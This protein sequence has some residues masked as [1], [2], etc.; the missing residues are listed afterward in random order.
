MTLPS[1]L[2][3]AIDEL[4]GS[5]DR[6]VVEAAARRLSASYREGGP[7]AVRAVRSADDAAAYL[8]TRA[9]A[10]YAAA[11]A[12]FGQVRA[13]RPGWRP[14]SL[15]DLGA[16]PGIAA[17]AAVATWPDITRV[18]CVEAELAMVTAGRTLAGQGP[19]ALC[20]A[21]W[22][23]EAVGSNG[24]TADLVVVSYVLG[25]LE[26]AAVTGFTTLSWRRSGDTLAVIEPG[27]PAGYERILAAR[28]A[29]IAEG[30]STLA[31]CPH[32]DPCPLGAGDWCHFSVRLSRSRT[33]REVKGVERG[34]ED[35]KVAYAV[36]TRAKTAPPRA[37]IIRRPERNPG[38][39]VLTLCGPHGLERRTVARSEK[40]SYRE[41]RKAAWGETFGGGA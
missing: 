38:H 26:P 1:G 39:V 24:G 36:L 41:A 37:R 9:P 20:Q 31:P 14:S 30:G 4:I 13:V 27:T 23:H 25:E 5:R 10:T 11:E 40:Q 16:G 21:T 34:F 18:S 29:V 15:L 32:D 33:H 35:E 6:R 17:W 22:S 8:A 12:V 28:S 2:R 19:T 3:A 7:A